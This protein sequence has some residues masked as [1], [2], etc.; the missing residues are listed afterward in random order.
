MEAA[1]I[2][3][4]TSSSGDIASLEKLS[5]QF[6]FPFNECT[7]SILTCM[8]LCMYNNMDCK[9]IIVKITFNVK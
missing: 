7:K 3:K 6:G 8:Y 1:R 2:P 9:R 5:S 4:Y